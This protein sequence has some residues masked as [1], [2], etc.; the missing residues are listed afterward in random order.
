MAQTNAFGP[1]M[2]DDYLYLPSRAGQA[3]I[4][5]VQRRNDTQLRFGWDV[6]SLD[7]YLTPMMPGDL[8]G[9]IARPGHGKTSSMIHI[10]RAANALLSSGIPEAENRFVVYVTWETLVEEFVVIEN[11]YRTGMSMMDVGR[12]RVDVD[13]L[14]A[15]I[16]NSINQR[17]AVIGQSLQGTNRRMPTLEDVDQVLT[18]MREEL[19][20]FPG[21][22]LFDYLQR[23]PA[24]QPGKDRSQ[25]VSE[26]LE[27]C[28]DMALAHKVPTVLAI[29]AKREVDEYKGLRLA[30][31]SDGQWTSNIEQTCDKVISITRPAQYMPEGQ[32]I[33]DASLAEDGEGGYV[34]TQKSFALRVVKQRWAAAGKTIMTD[35]DPAA[36][37]ITEA[38]RLEVAY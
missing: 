34:C 31:M 17:I 16:A 10:A 12:G 23:M 30:S 11:A 19:G 21:L 1:N 28:K 9:L 4:K 25:I 13:V 26:N 8:C 22:L 36:C 14:E 38:E 2:S 32:P 35:L 15:S 24:R 7:G 37:H 5:E 6:D 33:D 29:Q 3:A 20:I 18:E 27:R